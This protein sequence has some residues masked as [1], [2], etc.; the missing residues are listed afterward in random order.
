MKKILIVTLVVL[1]SVSVLAG[2]TPKAVETKTGLASI[3]S[4][5]KSKDV[6]TKDGAPVNGVGQ[7]DTIMAAVTV[8]DDGKVI[9]CKIDFVIAKVNFDA[10]GKVTTDKASEVKTKRELGDAYGMK[11]ASSIKKEWYEQA[12]AIEKWMIGKTIEQIKAMKTATVEGKL[13]TD[14]ADLKTS[15]TIGIKDY[16]DVVVKAIENAK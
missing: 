5:A 9:T 7:A 4:L 15:A 2:C 6:S 12:D 14:E 13:L 3:T 8:G 16:R 1:M 11:A 10:T